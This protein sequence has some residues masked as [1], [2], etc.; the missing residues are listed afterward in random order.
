MEAVRVF[1]EFVFEKHDDVVVIFMFRYSLQFL[2][3][4]INPAKCTIII[5][6]YSLERMAVD[7]KVK[8][9]VRATI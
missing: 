6:S 7:S 5:N 1:K 4:L 9:A 8:T 3:K 2:K